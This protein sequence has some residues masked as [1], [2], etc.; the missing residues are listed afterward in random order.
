M[1]RVLE[2]LEVLASHW[3][4]RGIPPLTD[5]SGHDSRLDERQRSPSEESSR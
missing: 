3:D 4:H 5:M 1:D 2:E